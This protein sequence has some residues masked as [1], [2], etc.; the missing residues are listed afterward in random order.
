MSLNYE[1]KFQPQ[2]IW[3][4]KEF[5]MERIY[6]NYFKSYLNNKNY[7]TWSSFLMSKQ[8]IYSTIRSSKFLAIVQQ[9][10][11]M[12]QSKCPMVMGALSRGRLSTPFLRLFKNN[13]TFYTFSLNI[14]WTFNFFNKGF[15]WV[16]PWKESNKYKIKHLPSKT[17]CLSTITCY[18]QKFQS[19]LAG[20]KKLAC[21]VCCLQGRSV[22]WG[23]RI[24]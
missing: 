20:K 23:I 14:I 16:E 9:Q 5:S 3:F 19:W 15:C 11:P 1:K 8:V 21:F 18:N 7:V 24:R 4:E 22:K 6:N 12:N 10:I 13:K 2:Y 17:D